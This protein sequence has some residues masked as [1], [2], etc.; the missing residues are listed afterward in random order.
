MT[1]AKQAWLE[2][3]LGK[4]VTFDRVLIHEANSPW[5]QYVEKFELQYKKDGNWKNILEGTKIGPDYCK[6]FDPVTARIRSAEHLA[7]KGCSLDMGIS[8]VR[9]EKITRSC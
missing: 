1:G 4:N 8:V 3:D 2:V 9:T 5:F 7:G 6:Q